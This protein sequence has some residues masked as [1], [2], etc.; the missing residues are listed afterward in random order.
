MPESC[1]GRPGQ[2]VRAAL[3]LPLLGSSLRFQLL[4]SGFRGSG[5]WGSE[6]QVSEL[7]FRVSGFRVYDVGCRV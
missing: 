6:I 5:I 3:P 4:D 7:K 2:A 1:M